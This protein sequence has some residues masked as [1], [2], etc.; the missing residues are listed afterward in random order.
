MSDIS[1]EPNVS[2]FNLAKS[3][4]QPA[5]ISET[6]WGYIVRNERSTNPFGIG[7][8]MA[9]YLAGAAFAAASLGLWL[10]PSALI[11]TDTLVMRLG[12][13]AIFAVTAWMLILFSR[14][15]GEIEWH[16]DHNLG[17][18]RKVVGIRGGK[19][20]LK[21]QYGF[22]SVDH[23]DISKIAN[24]AGRFS[25]G[26]RFC[27]EAADVEIA[28]GDKAQMQVISARLKSDFSVGQ[29]LR[30]HAAIAPDWQ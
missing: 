10:V 26:V 16:F 30:A 14:R 5:R 6:Y 13:S 8:Q 19:G 29:E 23:V 18:V 9:A 21:G 15:T 28:R 2:E 25:L 4:A 12:V 22:D 3:G 24:E 1:F 17:E 20:L 7:L 11:Q 27:G